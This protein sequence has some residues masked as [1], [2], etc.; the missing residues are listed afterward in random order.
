MRR[1][2]EK[3]AALCEFVVKLVRLAE[4]LHRPRPDATPDA[5][6][7]YRSAWPALD[8]VKFWCV[9]WMILLHTFFWVATD[10][11]YITFD[12]G[13]HV[14][15]AMRYFMV[16]GFSPLMLPVTAGCAFRL[17]LSPHSPMSR[18]DR[19]AL[20]RIVITSAFICC[21][22]FTMNVLCGGPSIV[23]A[24]NV[25]QLVAC[26]Y[27]LI[28]VVL[29]IAP[30]G[31]QIPLTAAILVVTPLLRRWFSV[32]DSLSVVDSYWKLALIGR[33]P[34][35]YGWP[36]FPWM[37]AVIFGFLLSDWYVRYGQTKRFRL[38][39]LGGGA[40][41]TL[42]PLMDGTFVPA[43]DR[44]DLMGA[45]MFNPPPTFILGVFGV[46]AMCLSVAMRLAPE[47]GWPRRG[48]VAAFSKGILWVYVCHMVLGTR[49]YEYLHSRYNPTGPLVS[50][51]GLTGPLIAV[52]FTLLMIAVSWLA[53]YTVLRLFGEKVIRVTLRRRPVI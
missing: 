48:I 1:V 7:R 4:P 16:F 24:W 52:A 38:A 9:L 33:V 51:P 36:L 43:F 29:L 17:S 42:V 15:R 39:L 32:E 37:S 40:V 2:R 31:M 5:L 50:I 13:G 25:L 30:V 23:F 46:A 53:G 41:L 12:L 18:L 22:G 47:R 3:G 6:A 19:A 10:S 26:S 11:G 49:L 8:L 14:F 44:T 35:G 34:S 27:I 28:G 21:A 45:L 20:L